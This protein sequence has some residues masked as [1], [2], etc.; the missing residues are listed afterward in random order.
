[1]TSPAVRI[2]VLSCVALFLE[3]TLIRWI[4]SVVPA[5][6]YFGNL[7]L[8]SSFLGLGL[9]S[10]NSRRFGRLVDWFPPLL[11]AAVALLMLAGNFAF[12]ANDAE[13]RFGATASGWLAYGS[14]VA[15][16]LFNTALFVPLGHGL[17]AEFRRLPALRAYAWDLTGS[18]AGTLIFAVFSWFSFSPALGVAAVGIL[19]LGVVSRGS[20]QAV[21]VVSA[22]A[23]TALVV[24]A[25]DRGAIWSPYHFITVEDITAA[26]G[27]AE[28]LPSVERLATIST[29]RD[30]PVFSVRVNRNFFQENICLD[31]RR[32]TPGTE[33]YDYVQG[34]RAQYAFPLRLADSLGRVLVLGAGGGTD[35]QAALLA[36]ASAVD[37][38]EIDPVLMKLSNRINAGQPYRD[39]RVTVHVDDAR[40]FLARTSGGYDAVIMGYLDS[41]GLFSSM[42]NVRLDGFMYTVEGLR[43]AFRAVKPG[44]VMVLSFFRG[45][46]W[47][48]DKLFGMVERACG[49]APK[50]Y[51]APGQI[52]L[53]VQK[54]P[55]RDLPDSIGVHTSVGSLNGKRVD[56][57]TDDWPYLYLKAMAIPPDYKAVIF[58]LVALSV[59]AVWAS[60]GI[61]VGRDGL[62]FMSLGAGFLLL[63]TKS[64]ADCSLY[65]GATWIVTTAVVAGVLL[66]VIAANLTAMG[67]RLPVVASYVGLFVALGLI[68]FVPR[69]VVLG[70]SAGSRLA[71]TVIAV[72]LPLFFAGLIFSSGFAD[73]PRPDVML[74]AN[75][76]GAML[77]GFAEYLSMAV[78]SER[79]FLA[80]IGCYLAS[81][82]F[83]WRT[84]RGNP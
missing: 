47:L 22:V 65:F 73:S 38:V 44:G 76:V 69:D 35:V 46:D 51:F 12:P 34:K 31:I 67:L 10:L 43:S 42:A 32:Y 71:W 62:H 7:L 6:A 66:M 72:P 75:L 64:I 82:A 59:A 50:A 48:S 52:T 3:L 45:P 5:V 49:A 83:R 17:G 81:A 29:Q 1:M 84:S 25:S 54:P 18:L 33:L 4:P 27:S 28:R 15:V 79:L 74:G 53:C 41:Q 58:S 70:W 37:A 2:S 8:V 24:L 11:L 14:L 60:S 56:S 39:P 20:R 63:E 80:I 9:G 77:G 16:F 78:G 61:A 30:P 23:A 55:L 68:W 19:T 13:L 21:A 40:A 36:G 57:A 26:P